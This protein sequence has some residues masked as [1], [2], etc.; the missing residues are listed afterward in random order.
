MSIKKYLENVRVPETPPGPF[1]VRLKYELR[2]EFFERKRSWYPAFATAA[3]AM[4][5]LLVMGFVMRPD[6]AH[7]LHYAF[8]GEKEVVEEVAQ[9]EPGEVMVDAPEP[10]LTEEDIY[11]ANQRIGNVSVVN[12]SVQ[13]EV[14]GFPHLV[15]GKSYIIRR[16]TDEKKGNVYYISEVKKLPKMY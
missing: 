8:A 15:E 9:I 7:N 12:D 5:F 1:S 3:A 16:G 4:M 11:L 6:F 2:K 14:A 10:F 13:G